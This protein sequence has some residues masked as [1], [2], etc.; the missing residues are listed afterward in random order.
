[1]SLVRFT[2]QMPSVFDR[3]FDG[4]LMDWSNDVNTTLPSVNIKETKE[5]FEVKVAA[6]GFDKNDFK[7][8]LNHDVLTISSEKQ[9]ENETKEDEQ[10]TRREYCYSSFKRSFVLPDSADAEKINA[11]YKNGILDITIPKKEEAKPKDKRVIKI[12]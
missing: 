7:L 9:A 10:Y 4:D 2:K 6:P 8:E 1:M 3:F 12:Q 5:G 11:E